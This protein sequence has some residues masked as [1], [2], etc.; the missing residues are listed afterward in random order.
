MS[1]ERP[2]RAYATKLAN[3]AIAAGKPTCWAEPFYREARG[4][5]DFIP[6]ADLEPNPNLV[7]WVERNPALAGAGVA[8]LVPGCG[9][10]DDAGYL[11]SRG[12]TV[13]AFDIAPTAV[14]W[15]AERFP[16]LRFFAA[17]LLALPGELNASFDLIAEIYT[18]Q[19]LPEE[20]RAPA[21][22]ALANCLKPGG[23]CLIICRGREDDEPFGELPWGVSK[24]ELSHLQTLGLQPESFE[25]YI[26][27]HTGSRRFRA[28][29]RRIT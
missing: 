27:A 6:W 5:P 28:L 10:G 11:A 29:Y 12:A 19:V 26:D 14:T 25:D 15:A 16:G 21:L 7:E 18:L 22:H 17:D 9:L 3:D 23:R 8:A 2:N 4:N 20:L 1:K 13:A 24:R